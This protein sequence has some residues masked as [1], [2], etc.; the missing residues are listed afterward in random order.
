MTWTEKE[1]KNAVPTQKELPK[2]SK[3]EQNKPTQAGDS[4]SLNPAISSD[5]TKPGETPQAKQAQLEQVKNSNSTG[6]ASTQNYKLPEGQTV[7]A[8]N[9][10]DQK[11]GQTFTSL[12]KSDGSGW[13]QYVRDQNTL[14]PVDGG[15]VLT[16]TK[17]GYL[18]PDNTIAPLLGR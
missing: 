15:P 5:I 11:T 1:S 8:L 2:D 12:P 10:Y 4:H 6:F 7:Q 16:V 18:K 14:R 3:G 13:T 9:S 17:D